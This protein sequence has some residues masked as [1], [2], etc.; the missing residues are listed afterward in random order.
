MIIMLL[1]IIYYAAVLGTS[2]LLA[3]LFRDSVVFD[4]TSLVPF[5]VAALMLWQAYSLYT[6]YGK[7]TEDNGSTS[8]SADYILCVV[9]SYLI[10]TPFCFPL[11]FFLNSW[12]K[13]LSILPFLLAIFAGAAVYKRRRAKRESKKLN[14]DET[15]VEK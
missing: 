3:F 10:F 1:Y 4:W 9:H 11:M 15:E 2:V 13:S 14:T 12:G 7:K 8:E 5:L 6:S